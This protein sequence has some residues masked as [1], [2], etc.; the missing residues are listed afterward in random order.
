MNIKV[1][2]LTDATLLRRANAFTTGHNSKMTLAKAYCHQHSPIRTQLF[3]VECYGIPLFV[4]SHFV[5]HNVGVQFFQLSKRPDRG[6][7]D[8]REV[9]DD[10]ANGLI[11]DSASNFTDDF[12]NDVSIVRELPKRFDRYAPVDLAFI[13]NAEALMNMSHKRLCFKASAETRAVMSAIRDEI[14][15]VDPDL[16]MHMVSQCVYRGGI[17][18]EPKSCGWIKGKDGA[19][20]LNKYRK[21][22]V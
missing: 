20:K 19:D 16:A 5:R 4:A 13:A 1:E 18:S 2:K 11:M 21:L 8:F 10:L 15:R 22:F 17:C 12:L 9:C 7:E 6:G 14:E 3:W